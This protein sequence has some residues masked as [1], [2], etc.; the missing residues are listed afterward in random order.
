[1][2]GAKKQPLIRQTYYFGKKTVQVGK[3]KGGVKI[4]FVAVSARIAAAVGLKLNL[5]SGIPGT[6]YTV[7]GGL[8]FDNHTSGKS[9]VSTPVIAKTGSKKMTVYFPKSGD[10]G[11]HKTGGAKGKK[12]T[13]V[14]DVSSVVI[15][16]P[17]WGDVATARKFLQGSKAINFSFG[18]G[19]P[20][21]VNSKEVK[22]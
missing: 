4:S 22:A 1:M 18:G 14:S 2:A 7:E 13:T 3:L 12:S 17:A 15:G 9:K 10:V 6:T 16:I 20:Y 11:V 8:I 21:P 19:D 5:P